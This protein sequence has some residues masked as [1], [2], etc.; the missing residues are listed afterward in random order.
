[1]VRHDAI[2]ESGDHPTDYNPDVIHKL[3]TLILV[4]QIIASIIAIVPS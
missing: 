3:Q 1:M 2:V 4:L